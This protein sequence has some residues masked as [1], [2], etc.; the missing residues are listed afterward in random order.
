MEEEFRRPPQKGKE[1]RRKQ[2]KEAYRRKCLENSG[3][4][5]IQIHTNAMRVKKSISW[6][7]F[8]FCNPE[9]A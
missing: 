3:A 2:H 8:P 1:G 9:M 4:A 5:E 7:V 6:L